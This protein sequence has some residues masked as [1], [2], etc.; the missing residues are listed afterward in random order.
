MFRGL[1][2]R[3]VFPFRSPPTR[4]HSFFRRQNFSFYCKRSS[5]KRNPRK[6]KTY[7]QLM[8][9]TLIWSLSICGNE[10][11]SEGKTMK[12][13]I[14]NKW[15]WKLLCCQTNSLKRWWNLRFLREKVSILI[16]MIR[17]ALQKNLTRAVNSP[18]TLK[19]SLTSAVV[20]SFGVVTRSILVIR[21]CGKAFVNVW[22]K[23]KVDWHFKSK[24][25]ANDTRLGAGNYGR[26]SI[27][28]LPSN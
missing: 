22:T 25:C 12:Q 24:V 4:Y 19:L 3:L 10:I 17:Y 16:L 7:F 15:C 18:L 11:A 1:T 14:T 27:F 21:V 23:T 9:G 5:A 2:L 26:K 6:T 8:N 28:Y 20:R 13:T